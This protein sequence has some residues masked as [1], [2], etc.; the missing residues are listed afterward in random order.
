MMFHA[1][2]LLRFVSSL[3]MHYSICRCEVRIG[4]FE[5][6]D[7]VITT[8]AQLTMTIC[9]PVFRDVKSR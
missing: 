5:N 1:R 9:S 6:T 7:I 8:F 2:S 3:L 4:E